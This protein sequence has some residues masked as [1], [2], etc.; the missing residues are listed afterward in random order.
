MGSC[1]DCVTSYWE[2]DGERAHCRL[3]LLLDQDDSLSDTLGE[4]VL[5]LCS[6]SVINLSWCWKGGSEQDLVYLSVPDGYGCRQTP[7]QRRALPRQR[8]RPP[9]KAK[10]TS[11]TVSSW[12][13]RERGKEGR[14]GHRGGGRRGHKGM[15]QLHPQKND[16]RNSTA[17]KTYIAFWTSRNNVRGEPAKVKGKSDKLENR[18]KQRK[19]FFQH[20][21]TCCGHS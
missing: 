17:N 15:L 7:G 4:H 8:G 18:G 1:I 13:R 10:L 11:P 14:K 9:A 20:R 5:Y 3:S 6:D 12:E 19:I 2:K 16:Q 21:H